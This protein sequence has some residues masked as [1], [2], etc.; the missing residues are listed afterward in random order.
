MITIYERNIWP[1]IVKEL[2]P[3]YMAMSDFTIT[4]EIDDNGPVASKLEDDPLLHQKVIDAVNDCVDEITY[5]GLY[6]TVFRADMVMECHVNTKNFD[7]LTEDYQRFDDYTKY[8]LRVTYVQIGQTVSKT[9]DAYAKDKRAVGMYRAGIFVKLTLKLA[10]IAFSIVT[11]AVG[12]A[13]A[14]ASGGTAIPAA[15]PGTIVGFVGLVQSAAEMARDIVKAIETLDMA[16]AD[17][18]VSLRKLEKKYEGKGTRGVGTRE[19]LAGSVNKIFSGFI[20][21]N[22]ISTLSGKFDL[23]GNKILV[24]DQKCHSLARKLPE[25]FRKSLEIQ[26]QISAIK[27]PSLPSPQIAKRAVPPPVPSRAGRRSINSLGVQAPVVPSRRGRVSANAYRDIYSRNA[28]PP[29]PSRFG[30]APA[31]VQVAPPSTLE[32]PTETPRCDQKAKKVSALN[33]ISVKTGKVIPRISELQRQV[34]INK[35]QNQFYTTAFNKLKRKK[36][37]TAEVIEILQGVS[38][39]LTKAGVSIGFGV[40]GLSGGLQTAKGITDSIHSIGSFAVEQL[41]ESAY[42]A[43]DLVDGMGELGKALNEQE[44]RRKNSRRTARV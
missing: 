30:R 3:R 37:T 11:M 23:W 22:T 20:E 2:H 32:K 1:R 5:K 36:S 24:V 19:V 27:S 7:R 10:G 9:I 8:L 6:D 16:R 44:L 28:P 35:K 17:A 31:P 13:S 42:L 26:S 14:I 40:D 4:L 41:V 12:T 43:N 18:I 39:D 29:V 33:K 21:M 38:W 15:I 25:L 34:N